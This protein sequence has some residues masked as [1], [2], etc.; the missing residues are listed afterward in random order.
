MISYSKK[1]S[2]C[3]LYWNHTNTLIIERNKNKQFVLNYRYSK[4]QKLYKNWKQ[5]E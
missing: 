3:N 4:N 1:S 5:I 2:K